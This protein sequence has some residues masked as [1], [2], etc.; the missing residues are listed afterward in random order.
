MNL[1]FLQIHAAS[2]P[3]RGRAVIHLESFILLDKAAVLAGVPDQPRAPA[4]EM[5]QEQMSCIC[6]NLTF[7]LIKVFNLQRKLIS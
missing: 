4:G 3:T 5:A 1:C 7:V 2:I 6:K